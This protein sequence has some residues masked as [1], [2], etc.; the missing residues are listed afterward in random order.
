MSKI[1]DAVV[2]NPLHPEELVSVDFEYR[3]DRSRIELV[4][5]ALGLPDGSTEGYFLLDDGGQKRLL[6]ERI[7]GIGKSGK[8]FVAHAVELAE[9]RCFQE[10]GL[11]PSE[12][13]FIDTFV[14][15]KILTNSNLI[16]RPGCSLMETLK[17]NGVN[18]LRGTSTEE[19]KTLMRAHIIYDTP[20][21]L[22]KMKDSILSYCTDDILD[23]RDLVMKQAD[24]YFRLLDNDLNRCIFRDTTL[25]KLKVHPFEYMGHCAAVYSVIDYRG[26]GVDDGLLKRL[27]IK[28]REIGDRLRDGFN[29]SFRIYSRGKDGV[30]HENMEAKL[31]ILEKEL[32]SL[33]LLEGWPRTATGNLSVSEK[34][35]KRLKDNPRAV[36]ANAYRQHKKLVTMFNGLSREENKGDFDSFVSNGGRTGRPGWLSTFRDGRMHPTHGI[37]YGTQTGRTAGKP[38]EG[39]IPCWGKVLRTILSAPEGKA[40]V[41][42]DFSSEEVCVMADFTGDRDMMDTYSGEDFYWETCRKMRLTDK[43]KRDKE[44]PEDTLLRTAVK[45]VVLGLQFG[46]GAETLQSRLPE[47]FDAEF[48]RDEYLDTF[49]DMSDCVDDLRDYITYTDKDF[50]LV[51][52]DG[53]L[54]HIYPESDLTKSVLSMSNFPIQGTGSSVL[55]SIVCI[56]KKK[57][58]LPVLTIHDE[59]IVETD[60]ATAEKDAE[61]I[62][63]AMRV[64]FRV[65]TGYDN[66]KVGS[67]EISLHGEKVCHDADSERKWNTLL[68]LLDESE[69]DVKTETES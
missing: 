8:I 24:R 39:Y 59:V 53:F 41:G 21:D 68:K 46:M 43:E 35:L 52:P 2:E 54:I 20:E 38:T 10:L 47:G 31:G 7:E 51:L 14:N 63:E 5:C 36:F 25:M 69:N 37:T 65:V 30:M 17:R 42:E 3:T 66:I 18:S 22:R 28:A 57:G 34:D 32:S 61:T 60:A 26:V 15:E 56:L 58:L 4:C 67:P 19:S 1:Y 23:L 33:G 45:Q 62:K 49:C 64:A 48:L 29:E 6:K 40:L 16:T 13:R 44:S 50:C 12:F 27:E 9:G 11:D 55:R